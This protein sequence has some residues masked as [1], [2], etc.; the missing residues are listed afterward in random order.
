MTGQ[1]TFIKRKSS[2]AYLL[3]R[4]TPVGQALFLALEEMIALKHLTKEQALMV[5][6]QYDFSVRKIIH[7]KGSNQLVNRGFSFQAGIRTF[8]WFRQSADHECCHVLFEDVCFYQHFRPKVIQSFLMT[9]PLHA[10]RKRAKKRDPRL[11][12]K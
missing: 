4:E 10:H 2:K 5:V 7:E 8:R 12:Q 3:Y 9:S 6:A 1:N 11:A